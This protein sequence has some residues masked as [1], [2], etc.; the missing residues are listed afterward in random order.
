MSDDYKKFNTSAVTGRIIYLEDD[1]LKRML[2]LYHK[3][4]TEIT[5]EERQCLRIFLFQ[6]FTSLRISDAMAA[7]WSWVNSRNEMVFIPKKAQRFKK[8]VTVPLGETAL[9]LIEKKRGL[10]FDSPAEQTINEK[11]KLCADKV[12]ITKHITTH[13][14]RHTYGTLFYRHTKDILSLNKIMGHSKLETTMVYAHINDEDKRAGLNKYEAALAL[15]GK[16]KD[17]I[18]KTP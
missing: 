18:T 1:E 3:D 12:G 13:V 6:C 5:D 15:L 4:T 14:G 10:F 11:I 17:E 9:S 2:D 8:Q 7:N 16:E